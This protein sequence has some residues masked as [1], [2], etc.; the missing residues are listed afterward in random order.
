MAFEVAGSCTASLVFARRPYP[1]MGP[2]AVRE[3]AAVKARR[4]LA[5]GRLVVRELDE[6]AGTVRASCRGDGAVYGLGRD[7]RGWSCS[8]PA[9]GRCAHLLAL[10]LVVALGPREAS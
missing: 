2:T 3:S 1:P 7:A 6:R 9:V 8:C 4:Y 5:E 10:G